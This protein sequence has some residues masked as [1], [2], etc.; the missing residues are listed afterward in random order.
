MQKDKVIRIRVSDE[1]L[2]GLQEKAK[3]FKEKYPNRHLSVGVVVRFALH[4]FL[5][6]TCCVGRS[7]L[8]GVLSYDGNDSEFLKLI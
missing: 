6:E 4:C 8:E 5:K 3:Q 2:Q 1:M 7:R